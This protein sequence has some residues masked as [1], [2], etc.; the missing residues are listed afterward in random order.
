MNRPTRTLAR[1]RSACL[2]AFLSL[3][4][5]AA[6][7]AES[8]SADV[9]VYGGTA[10]GAIAAVAAAREGKTVLLVEPGHHIGGMV[11][12]G[13][14]ATDFGNRGAIGGYSREFFDR[15]REH[16]IKQY[17]ADSKQVKDCSDGFHFEPHVA[18]TTFRR[19]LDEA[20]VRVV[21]DR[22]LK[23]IKN[24]GTR[25][26]SIRAGDDE[27]A[28]TVFID[29]SYEG[30]LLA[31]AKVSY[32]VGR[33][34]RSQYNES[35]AGV[36]AHSPAHQWPVKVSPYDADRKLL[37]CVQPG[38]G[39][40]AGA[41]DRKVQAYNYRLCMTKVPENRVPFPKPKHYD[42]KRYELLA[43]YLEAKPGLTVGQL[44]NPVLMPNGK[45]DTN[46]NGAFS[47]DHIGANWDYPD[48]DATTRA[49]IVQDHIDYVQGFLYFLANDPRV[50]AEL[51]EE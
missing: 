18:E 14:G 40:E 35:L 43:R 37:P 4:L 3:A 15:V 50:P 33:E 30:D 6:A 47:T 38:P 26:Q 23:S 28:G 32:T 13:L 41:G 16:Y 42:P 12:G 27:I 39:G 7:Q 44:M 17:G 22:P 24:E 5:A 46:N 9:V 20:R 19:M 48:G 51:H 2:A 49:R 31:Q 45:T 10:G 29:A 21:L 36:Q 1:G 34:A 25:I 8:L 11:S